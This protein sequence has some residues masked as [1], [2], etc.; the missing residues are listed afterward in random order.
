MPR[1][2]REGSFMLKPVSWEKFKDTAVKFHFV[3][4]LGNT[5]SGLCNFQTKAKDGTFQHNKNLDIFTD[6]FEANTSLM[7]D[8][9]KGAELA[10][11]T[12]HFYQVKW[13]TRATPGETAKDSLRAFLSGRKTSAETP[14]S[15]ESEEHS[16]GFDS[17]SVPF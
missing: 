16:S 6:H 2:Q 14:S 1:I 5:I 3:D 9:E 8:V 13:P 7:C 11:G 4:A 10:D 17:T 12:G 15:F